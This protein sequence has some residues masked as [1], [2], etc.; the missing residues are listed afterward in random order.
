MW[1]E[2]DTEAPCS[3]GAGAGVTPSLVI[4]AGRHTSHSP[5][6]E[7]HQST[8]CMHTCF[9]QFIS[10]Q[11]SIFPSCGKR[12]WQTAFSPLSC[13]GS[14]LYRALGQNQAAISTNSGL[15]AQTDLLS[16]MLRTGTFLFQLVAIALF[17]QGNPL[18]LIKRYCMWR[19]LRL[20]HSSKFSI[21]VSISLSGWSLQDC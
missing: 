2:S 7:T 15:L 8:A 17:S 5:L 18:M 10:M 11:I 19:R 9:R 3:W 21:V 13:G 14:R 12:A 16:F 6:D 20:D 4:H 1:V